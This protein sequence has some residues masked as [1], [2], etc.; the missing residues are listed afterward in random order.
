MSI[1]CLH[2]LQLRITPCRTHAAQSKVGTEN[3]C[4]LG[5][6]VADR[7]LAAARLPQSAVNLWAVAIR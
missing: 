2:F 6:D 5:V 3:A 4:T 1:A 7:G